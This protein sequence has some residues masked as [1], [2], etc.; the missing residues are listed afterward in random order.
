MRSLAPQESTMIKAR[1]FPKCDL[2]RPLRPLFSL[3]T[4]PRTFLRRKHSAGK[5]LVR[6][7]GACRSEQSTSVAERPPENET[8]ASELRELFEAE[9]PNHSKPSTRKWKKTAYLK[10]KKQ[11]LL[12][13]PEREKPLGEC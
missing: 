5:V 12:E 11:Q 2:S 6:R 9:Q 7:K 3:D 4:A 1:P 10:A 13:I 8:S